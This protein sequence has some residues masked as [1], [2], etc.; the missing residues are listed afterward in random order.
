[1]IR[2]DPITPMVDDQEVSGMD[3]VDFDM[4]DYSIEFGSKF[5]QDC[6]DELKI[7]HSDLVEEFRLIQSTFQA[8]YEQAYK[9]KKLETEEEIG[10]E[11]D[12]LSRLEL[13]RDEEKIR[14]NKYQKILTE[15]LHQKHLQRLKEI[16]FSRFKTNW[17]FRKAAAEKAKRHWRKVQ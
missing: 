10:K 13:I 11:V 1:M 6:Q 5:E 15:A 14:A 3:A 17:E 8:D 4:D 12:E 9:K 7:L 16:A 2:D